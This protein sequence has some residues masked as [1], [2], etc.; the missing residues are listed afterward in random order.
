MKELSRIIQLIDKNKPRKEE[1]LYDEAAESKYAQLYQLIKEGRVTTDEEAEAHFYQDAKAVGQS[2]Y[3]QFKSRFKERVMNTLFFLD[4]DNA[5]ASDLHNATLYILKEWAAINIIYAKGDFNLAAKL[6]EDLLPYA[7]KYEATETVIY[8]TDRLRQGYGTQIANRARYDE[9]KEVQ[10]KYMELWRLEILARETFHAIRMDY[11]KSSATQTDSIE[12]GTRGAALLTPFLNS[13][14]TYQ[15]ITYTYAVMLAQ[16]DNS[17][18]DLKAA[19]VLCDEAIAFL[20]QK[21]FN[22]KKQM[23]TFM[24]QKIACYA[25]LKEQ[26]AG[27]DVAKEALSLQDKGS[28]SWFKTLEYQA[29]LAFM[30]KDYL[31]AFTI[32]QTAQNHKAFKS[33]TLQHAE[34]WRL[35]SAYLHFLAISEKI[36]KEKLKEFKFKSAKFVND[37]PTFNRDKEGMNVPSLIAQIAILIAEKKHDDIPDRLDA[38]EKYRQRHIKKTDAS[39]RNYWFIKMLQEIPKGYYKRISIKARTE[40]MLA[41]LTAVPLKNEGEDAK[42]DQKNVKSEVIP[43]EDLWAI[44][45]ELM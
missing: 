4:K 39:Y 35:F 12:K 42:N 26:T 20:S 11:I 21:P 19:I 18:E 22:P 37:I 10:N 3:R 14:S 34:I 43:L 30:T 1:F 44:L 28:F 31:K 25:Q 32:C 5:E 9:L 36:D 15:F 29:F 33:L 41:N 2:A 13:H 38:L 7:M 24:N 6:A 16:F 45:L 23:T 17:P 40:A 27:E 8:I